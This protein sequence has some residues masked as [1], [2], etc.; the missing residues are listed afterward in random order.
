MFPGYVCVGIY[1]KR[2]IIYLIWVNQQISRGETH[3]N[4][5]RGMVVLL[6]C[7]VFVPASVNNPNEC[8]LR[9]SLCRRPP[10]R[11]RAM[12]ATRA[13]RCCCFCLYW[14]RRHACVKLT[15]ADYTPSRSRTPASESRAIGGGSV[16][17]HAQRIFT[18]SDEEV[19]DM[20]KTKVKGASKVKKVSTAWTWYMCCCGGCVPPFG[21]RPLGLLFSGVRRGAAAAGRPRREFVGGPL[22]KQ[23]RWSV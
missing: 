16:R 15:N 5:V 13:T 17:L 20:L 7:F 2:H 19:E 14:C 3:R 4:A 11:P 6:F 1:K 8:V 10:A 12:R 23:G 18:V 21:V 22:R 9:P